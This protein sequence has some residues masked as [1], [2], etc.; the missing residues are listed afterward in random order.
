MQRISISF[1]PAIALLAPLAW[2]GTAQAGIGACG[3]IHVEAEAECEVKGGVECTGAC[4]PVSFEAECAAELSVECGGQ[5]NA[6][7]SAECTGECS[8]SCMAECDELT[9]GSFDCRASCVA[10]CSGSCE[11]RCAADASGGECRASCEAT[12]EG[13]CSADCEVVPPM[14]DCSAQCEASCSGRCDAEA[15]IDCQIDCQSEGYVDCKAE[16]QGGCE[17]ECDVEQGA[18]FCDGQYV[19]H[20][21]N[22][23]ECIDS[24][25]A[26]LN[27]EVEGY[28]EAECSGN[29]CEAAAGGSIA[30]AVDETAG[31]FGR[32]GA[33]MGAFGL[34]VAGFFARRR[35]S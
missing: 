34:M 11:G 10:D 8:G 27:I 13:S 26:V 31:D 25:R 28:A 3:D 33:L 19:D 1:L 21:N 22:L 2:S 7:I 32:G 17:V 24:L 29:S 18:L 16:L 6:E 30:C 12:C 9:A 15:N 14:A 35:R 5:C 23:E 20:G 4:T